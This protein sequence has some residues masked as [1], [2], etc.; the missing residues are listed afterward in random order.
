VSH[1]GSYPVTDDVNFFRVLLGVRIG[2]KKH[3]ALSPD[4]HYLLDFTAK[5]DFSKEL[6]V[7]N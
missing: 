6:E 4:Y 5:L 1:G 7:L 2:R 3:T